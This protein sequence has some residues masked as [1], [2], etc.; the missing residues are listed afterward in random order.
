MIALTPDLDIPHQDHQTIR[1]WIDERMWGHRIWD[2][3]TPWLI[4]LEFVGIAESAQ[5]EGTLLDEKG[6]YYPLLFHPHQRILLRNLLYNN[7]ILPFILDRYPDNAPGMERMDSLD[8]RERS[9]S[10]QE[11]IQLPS[12]EICGISRIC[13]AHYHVANSDG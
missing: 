2:N 9:R 4:F 12:R 10:G 11:T 13:T 7:Q 5:R 3:Q 1:Y 8:G 6:S